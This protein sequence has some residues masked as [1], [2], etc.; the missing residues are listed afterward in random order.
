MSF[1]DSASCGKFSFSSPLSSLSQL[2][3]PL[4]VVNITIRFDNGSAGGQSDIDKSFSGLQLEIISLFRP[5][6]YTPAQLLRRASNQTSGASLLL[7]PACCCEHIGL[8][9]NRAGATT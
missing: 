4:V 9:T 7:F 2:P 1:N 8:A 3:F 6:S 5:A